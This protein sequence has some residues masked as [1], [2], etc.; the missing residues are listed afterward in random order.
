MEIY[1][2]KFQAQYVANLYK[3]IGYENYYNRINQCGRYLKY[4]QKIPYYLKT[5]SENGN[6]EVCERNRLF[7]F[8][9]AKKKRDRK[10]FKKENN[11][12]KPDIA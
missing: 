1:N 3:Q 8:D 7:R 11:P 6:V 5:D 4:V 12:E 10:I 9:Y 2:R